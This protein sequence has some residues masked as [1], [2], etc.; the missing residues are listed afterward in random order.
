MSLVTIIREPPMLQKIVFILLLT[1]PFTAFSQT[2]SLKQHTLNKRLQAIAANSNQNIPRKINDDLTDKG[3]TVNG[4]TLTNHIEVST[5][6]ASQMRQNPKATYFQL[7][8][9]VCRNPSYA[10]LLK[11]GARLSYY[12]TE[13]GTKKS[14]AKKHFTASDCGF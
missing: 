5:A 7:G 8:A 13:A 6:Q 11:E 4:N 14:I 10:K 2:T 9:S 1:S 12:F 3:Y